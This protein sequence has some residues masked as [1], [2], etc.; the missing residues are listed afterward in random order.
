MR[1]AGRRLAPD[2]A[3]GALCGVAVVLL[4]ILPFA[5]DHLAPGSAPPRLFAAAAALQ[6]GAIAWAVA[7]RWGRRRRIAVAL[8]ACGMVS[9][10]AAIPGLPAR[11]IGLAVTGCLDTLAYGGLLAWFAASLRP[12]REPVVTGFARR[13][14]TAMPA[15]VLRYTRRVTLAWC[16]FFAVH[17]AVSATLLACAPAAVWTGF[18]SLLNL[19]LLAAMVLGEFALRLILFRH[20]T[21]TGL[22]ATLSAMRGA[23]V[24]RGGRR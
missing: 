20:E 10:V 18:V 1:E 14:R 15:K 12:G 24:L 7:G 21:R 11:D 8:G 22:A 6:A 5:V 17:L 13:V 2:R 9:L 19:P 23:N 16:G 4:A 3:S